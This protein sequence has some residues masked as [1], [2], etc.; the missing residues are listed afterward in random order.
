MRVKNFREFYRSTK[1]RLYSY[2]MR[3]SG[4]AELSRDILQESF[5]KYL[6]RYGSEELSVALLYTIARN[7]FFDDTRKRRLTS[8]SEPDPS[9]PGPNPERMLMVREDYRQVM[10]A[11][12]QLQP[13]EREVLSLVVSSGLSYRGV[14][15]IVGTSEANVKVR[16]HRARL[17]LRS[18][19]KEGRK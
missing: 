18:A 4:D 9:D 14:A 16:V 12:Q 17:K 11:L 1:D 13:T 6:E 5:T 2:L 19:L 15:E 10:A 3:M 7:A 8:A